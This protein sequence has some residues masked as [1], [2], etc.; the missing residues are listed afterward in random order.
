MADFYADQAEKNGDLTLIA[1]S[2]SMRST[3]REK[4]AKM[5]IIDISIA[6][7]YLVNKTDLTAQFY[8]YCQFHYNVCQ[9]ATIS[10]SLLS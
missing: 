10:F 5:T 8:I 2:N 9:P 1:K 3:A 7:K 4:E 6:A